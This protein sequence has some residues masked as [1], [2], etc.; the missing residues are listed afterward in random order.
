MGLASMP[1][2]IPWPLPYA[3]IVSALFVVGDQVTGIRGTATAL[4]GPNPLGGAGDLLLVAEEPGVGLGARYAGL[5]GPDP[6][7]RLTRVPDT[8]LPVGGRLA[9]L[10][11]VPDVKE[12][13]AYVGE[14]EGLWLWAVFCPESAS[15]LLLEDLRLVDLRDLGDEVEL[16]PYGALPPWLSAS[17]T[18]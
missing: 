12:R 4:S 10:W 1:V 18:T 15:A 6:G 17:E 9:P 7:D 14:S 2:W 3:W 16:V 13:S 5:L 11:C 8:K